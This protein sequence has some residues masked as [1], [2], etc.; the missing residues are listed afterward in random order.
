MTHLSPAVTAPTNGSHTLLYLPALD[1]LRGAAVA[2]VIA[3]HAHWLTGGYLGVDLFFVLSGF[4]ITRLLL[5]EYSTSGRID[6]IGF[7]RRR[8]RRLLPAMLIVTCF[9][10]V[11]ERWRDT[12]DG[13]AGGRRDVV[14]AL[15]Y[16][17]NWLRLD[18]GAGYWR[19]FGDPAV[20]DHMWSLAIE[21]QFYVVWPVLAFGLFRC[22]RSDIARVLVLG[23]ASCGLG[24]WALR[25]FST[26]SDA[27]R[28]YMG[29]D[30]RAVALLLGATVAATAHRRSWQSNTA[31]RVAALPALV[32]LAIMTV[33]MRGDALI[34]Y[35]GGLLAF[36][37][38]GAVVVAAAALG[39]PPAVFRVFT[40]RPLRW[41]GSRS[42]GIYLWH[43][44]IMVGLHVA[45][46]PDSSWWR[47]VAAIGASFAIAEVSYRF[48]EQP[49]RKNGLNAFRQPL[50]TLAVGVGAVAFALVAVFAPP[51]YTSATEAVPLPSVTPT[52][53][54]APPSTE[55][56]AP[57]ASSTPTTDST[58]ALA[59]P[60]PVQPLPDDRPPRVM[61]V[62]DSVGWNLALQAD[63]EHERLGI[64]VINAA[65]N[66]CPLTHTPL[67]R[68]SD[69]S[70]VPL[71]FPEECND[72]VN[73]YGNTVADAQ[74]DVVIVVFGASFLDENEIAPGQ[75]HAPCSAPFDSWFQDQIR[76]SADALSSTGATVYWVTP[77]YYRG[78][79]DDRTSTWDDQVDCLNAR[80]RD[81]VERSNGAMGVIEL[82]EWACP[83]RDCLTERDGFEL[84]PDGTHFADQGASLANIW[85]LSQVFDPPPWLRGS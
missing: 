53:S 19:Q 8:A 48:I 29:T 76:K 59:S 61:F 15:T 46:M 41:L 74:P 36:S 35:Q 71:V 78:E 32:A 3:F 64:E 81:V 34:T 51:V 79:V 65:I 43:W 12:L 17:S 83:T 38:A 10:A 85:M 33:R 55:P 25:L 4:L 40:T 21:E 68:R 23:L 30:T 62:G 11:A 44:P 9:A 54:V 5:N 37:L 60:F 69:S 57:P 7:W 84:R 63:D 20:L 6:L 72:A 52:S 47:R 24:L 16:T 39:R 45:D 66:G 73:N 22:I 14:G 31:L 27:S 1:G 58:V 77:G 18:S 70:T 2:V 26:T 42:Y 49:L 28:V 67:R 50:R 75:W 13:P 56:V 82:G 80:A